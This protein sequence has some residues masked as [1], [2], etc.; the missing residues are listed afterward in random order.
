MLNQFRTTHRNTPSLTVSDPRGRDA[1]SVRYCRVSRADGTEMRVDRTVHDPAGRAIAVWDARLFHKASP[2]PN[3]SCVPSLSGAVLSSVSVDA[4]LRVSLFGEAGLPIQGWDG[5]G[6]QYSIDYDGQQRS[7]SVREHAKGSEAVYAERLCYAGNE[8]KYADQNQCGQLIRHDDPAGTQRVHAF[9]LAGS[10][11]VQSRHFLRQ[12]HS[13]DW[14]AS[15]V[16]RDALLEAGGEANTQLRCNPMGEV[17]EQTDAQGNRQFFNQTIAGQLREVRLQLRKDAKPTTLVSA[18]QY[19]AQGQTEREIAGNGVTTELDYDPENA[20][21]VRLLARRGTDVLQDLSYQYDPRGNVTSIKD[22]AMPTRYYANQR[23]EPISF[24]AYDSL[25]QLISATGW[26]AGGSNKGP[27]CS[28]FADPAP[29]SNYRQT[30]RYDR[31]GNLLEL[32]HEGAQRHGHRL[33]A[34]HSS[35]RCLPVTGGVEPGEKDFL[36]GFDANG[37]LLNLQPGQGLHWDVRN[38]L[39]EVNPVVR[40]SKIADSEHYVYGADGMRVRKVRSLQTGTQTNII[41]TR[42]LPGLQIRIH[43]GTAEQLH[44]I[45]VS[46]G[47]GSVRVLHWNNGKPP[48]IPDNQ[49]RY[50][51]TDHLGSSTLELDHDANV[52][53][54]ERY[55]PFGGTAWSFGESVQVSYKTVRYSGKERDTTGLYYY[56][57]R[58]YVPCFQRWLNPDPAGTVDGLNAYAMVSNSPLNK[59]DIAGLIGKDASEEVYFS[60]RGI[61]N[62]RRMEDYKKSHQKIANHVV[63]GITEA[64][65]R[66]ELAIGKLQGMDGGSDVPEILKGYLGDS[67]TSPVDVCKASKM[68]VDIFQRARNGLIQHQQDNY[69]NILLVDSSGNDSFFTYPGDSRIY[70]TFRAN[71]RA[72]GFTFARV[73]AHEITHSLKISHDIWTVKQKTLRLAAVGDKRD[74]DDEKAEFARI[75]LD[76]KSGSMFDADSFMASVE[77]WFAVVKVLIQGRE[78]ALESS[79][80]KFKSNENIRRQVT[81][82]NASSLESLMH[83][84]T[85]TE[86][87]HRHFPSVQIN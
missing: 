7:T 50:H 25:Y 86:V 31:G 16:E 61:S 60:R 59:H 17:I 10:P 43:S 64:I 72:N 47:R 9:G 57:F 32:V 8:Q 46:T 56:G 70:M 69:K 85:A 35:N 14:P 2:T 33:V 23:I 65:E 48:D 83:A 75:A 11:L 15:V 22:A 41:E 80:A 66:F 19:N 40:D 45:A 34:E 76:P 39:R 36:T 4:G 42:Y 68:L 62:V 74:Q 38:Q 49:H 6:A 28:T 3:L 84:L 63:S 73:F 37:N 44:I 79:L 51:L 77:G 54:Q 13:P 82:S 24:Y 18:I 81:F 87:H 5:R 20:R 26:E 1:R 30:Y 58:Y 55:Y 78:G 71:D 29:R 53:T 27:Q 21:L 12:L 67:A 52:I